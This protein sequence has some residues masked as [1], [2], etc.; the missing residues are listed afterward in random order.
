M[1]ESFLHYIWQYQYF[2]K[3][4]LRTPNFEEV[5]I[6][7]KGE[8]NL[9]AGPDFK[10]SKISINGIEWNGHIEIHVKSSEWVLHKHHLDPAYDNVIL[11][12]VWKDNR[13]ALRTDGSRI[14]T[15]E[16]GDR[17]AKSL[18][19]RSSGLLFNINTIACENSIKPVGL[20]LKNNMIDRAFLIRLEKSAERIIKNY[21]FLKYDWNETAYQLLAGNFGFRI[22]TEPFKRLSQLLPFKILMKHS[23]DLFQIEA[24][25]FGVAG[26]LNQNRC[27]DQYF[28]L[29]K[30]EYKFLK[31]KYELTKQVSPTQWRYLRLRPANFPVIR[32][33]QFAA[34]WYNRPQLFSKF[35]NI[36]TED[37]LNSI[38]HVKQS[39]YWQNHYKFGTV[40]RKPIPGMGKTSM[41]NI[42]INSIAPLIYAYG[43][44]NDRSEYLKKSTDLFSSTNAETNRL[45]NK[46]KK[47]G[48]K[49]K[50]ARQ[51]QGL[52]SLYQIFCKPKKCLQCAIGISIFKRTS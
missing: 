46:W 6:I 29:L 13:P 43:I 34:L 36:G 16:L 30:K 35:I 12:V 47:L 4:E 22:N 52:Y 28:L 19:N 2:N 44:Q 25:L 41:E 11:H 27:K 31:H 38:L 45:V 51:S 48:M 9:D 21:E 14:A 32:I 23:S 24:L 33:A 10:Y 42:I 7:S 8:Y 18:V 39:D 50:N 5:S 1:N 37:K 15:I 17:I 3:K 26:I 20:R 49:A 40:T